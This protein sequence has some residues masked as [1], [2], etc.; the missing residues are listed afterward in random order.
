MTPFGQR[1]RKLRADRRLSLRT[2]AKDI[3]V[4]PAY[5]SALERGQRGRPS[6]YLVQRVIAYFNVI[7]DDAEDLADMARKSHPKVTIN[8]ANLDISK[9][10]FIHELATTLADLSASEV[11][12]MHDIIKHRKS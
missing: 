6:W 9:V 8:T 1:V 10:E 11:Q 2:M 7:W 4:S 3:G 5:L 12:I